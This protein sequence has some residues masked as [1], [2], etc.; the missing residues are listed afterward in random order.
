MGILL[1]VVA[2]ICYILENLVKPIYLRLFGISLEFAISLEYPI[3]R[4]NRKI[5]CTGN[6]LGYTPG[7]PISQK[8]KTF[9]EPDL[10]WDIPGIW[11]IPGIRQIPGISQ[12]VE[13]KWVSPN[14]PG[15]HG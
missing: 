4:K 9:Y 5:L 6:I 13:G 1:S 12:K 2:G 3:F 10:F 11:Q 8:T 14:F 15:Y 7:Y